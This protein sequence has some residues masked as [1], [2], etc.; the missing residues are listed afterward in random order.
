MRSQTEAAATSWS[1]AHFY[2][3]RAPPP[4]EAECGPQ[5]GRLRVPGA[6]GQGL[7]TEMSQQVTSLASR[8]TAAWASSRRPARHQYYRDAKILTI[9]E[10]HDR[11]PGLI[12]G[13]KDRPRDVVA[14]GA[15]QIAAP[16][17][18]P[19]ARSTHWWLTAGAWPRAARPSWRWST[20][21]WPTPAPTPMPFPLTGALPDAG[22]TTCSPVGNSSGL[23]LL[24]YMRRKTPGTR[25]SCPAEV[26]TA[27][28]YADHS[29]SKLPGQ[30]QSTWPVC[31]P[32]SRCKSTGVE[33]QA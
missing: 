26:V 16:S 31:P 21:W 13:C 10:G 20:A 30:A 12:W 17:C 3:Q 33:S 4:D 6:G 8:S 19:R 9:Y 24:A 29:L 2:D 32:W 1:P 25:P 15:E 5:P 28:F 7:P 23:A 18:R 11:H 27:R 14:R 22:F